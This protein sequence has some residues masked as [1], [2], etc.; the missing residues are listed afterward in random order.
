MKTFFQFSKP[1]SHA[2]LEKGPSH[3]RKGTFAPIGLHRKLKGLDQD[4]RE[5]QAQGKLAS[6]PVPFSPSHYYDYGGSTRTCCPQT[7]G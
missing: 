4:A 3:Q 7:K 1:S 5:H 6:D 2:N